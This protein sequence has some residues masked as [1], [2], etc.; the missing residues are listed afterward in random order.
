MNRVTNKMVD[1]LIQ[2]M[3]PRVDAIRQAFGDGLALYG[4]GMV[5][6]WGTAYLKEMGATI[7][8]V[9]DGNPRKRGKKVD[10][11]PILSP[12]EGHGK[13]TSLLISA[14]HHVSAI[15]A[16]CAAQYANI[17]SLD[18]FII[19]SHYKR[20][21]KTREMLVDDGL[22]RQSY[23]AVLY[24]LLTSTLDRCYEVLAPDMYF[25]LPQ[26]ACDYSETFVDA[27][28]YVGD[29]VEKFIWK[30]GG[31]FK[32]IFAFEPGGRQFAAMEQR[33]QRLRAEWALDEEAITTVRAGLADVDG[34]MGMDESGLPTSSHGVEA[35][36]AAS[37]AV[38]VHRLDNYLDGQEVSFIKADVEGME[39]KLIA[40]ASRTIK[41]QRPRLALCAYHHPIDLFSLAE[42][43]S[44]LV[45]DYRLA[46]RW[47]A[48][49]LGDYVLYC[50]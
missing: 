4:A 11:T 1:A 9:I 31:S 37:Q 44:R 23:N 43:V 24:S 46:F 22:S 26:F 13:S 42:T 47:H 2:E 38:T 15:T 33:I 35:T 28:A 5:G 32:Q 19:V 30:C 12:K 16:Q 20:I 48:P 21:A 27:G 40:G 17:L 41:T 3:T 49:V 45:P 36:A 34:H 25:S 39:T 50:Y 29:T 8:C 6:Q 10:D 14:R 18:A 7:S